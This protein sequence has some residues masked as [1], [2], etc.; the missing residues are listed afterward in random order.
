M[1]ELLSA[2]PEDQLDIPLG[3]SV[4]GRIYDVNAPYLAAKHSDGSEGEV[5]PENKW[6]VNYVVI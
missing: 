2:L 1:I 5:D 4:R 3:A 6:L